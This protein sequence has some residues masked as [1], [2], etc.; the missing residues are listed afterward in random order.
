MNAL[1]SDT[2]T[3]LCET[4]YEAYR[5][6]GGLSVN[7][8]DD[9]TNRNP[10]RDPNAESPALT[11]KSPYDKCSNNGY[12]IYMTDGEPTYDTAADT[13]ISNMINSL[14]AADKTAVGYG[15]SGKKVI[16]QRWLLI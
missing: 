5:Y 7:F 16:W 13:L 14:P 11:Y 2:W 10:K 8:G 3:P 6:F 15:S 9:D 4:L 12:I 1:S